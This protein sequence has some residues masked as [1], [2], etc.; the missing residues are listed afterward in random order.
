M[1]TLADIC[2][3]VN[4]RQIEAIEESLAKELAKKLAE[5]VAKLKAETK[6][7]SYDANSVYSNGADGLRAILSQRGDEPEFIDAMI[8]TVERAFTARREDARAG[9]RKVE[10]SLKKA[11]SGRLFFAV[12]CTRGNT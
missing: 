2:A 7:K 10:S 6:R 3:R 12:N 11:Q 8:R 5:K 4:W 9:R 1:A